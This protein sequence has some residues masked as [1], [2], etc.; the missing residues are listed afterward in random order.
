MI[1]LIVRTW[2]HTRE[3]HETSSKIEN[4]LFGVDLSVDAMER[5]IAWAK[6]YQ[7]DLLV[8]KYKKP[9]RSFIDSQRQAHLVASNKLWKELQREGYTSRE[10]L[11]G[12]TFLFQSFRDNPE[13]IDFEVAKQFLAEL[14]KE[15]KAG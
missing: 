3:K 6:E 5:I 12:V 1:D 14:E 15:P 4:F 11:N 13:L 7:W 9:E 8:D 10:Q 2:S